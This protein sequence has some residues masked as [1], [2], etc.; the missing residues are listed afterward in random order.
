MSRDFRDSYRLQ[1]ASHVGTRDGIALELLE[2]GG[3]DV[4]AEVF[5]DDKSGELSF[6]W[7]Y[8]HAIPLDVAEWFLSEARRADLGGSRKGE[9]R[10]S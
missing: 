1:I 2:A 5:H 7:F 4:L 8:D 3:L 9:P 10:Q 6:G